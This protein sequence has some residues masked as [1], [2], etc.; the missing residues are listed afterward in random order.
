MW[1]LSALVLSLHISLEALAKLKQG[2]SLFLLIRE[3]LFLE[4]GEF[5][6]AE[7]FLLNLKWLLEERHHLEVLT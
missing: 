1:A 2:S 3:R 7:L 6:I 4:F 5:G